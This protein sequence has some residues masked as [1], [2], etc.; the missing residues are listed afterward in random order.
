MVGEQPWE[1]YV[2]FLCPLPSKGGC[3]KGSTSYANAGQAGTKHSRSGSVAA[4]DT[5][6]IWTLQAR[7]SALGVWPG[8]SGCIGRRSTRLHKSDSDIALWELIS[9]SNLVLGNTRH[10][11][12]RAWQ[13]VAHCEGIK[14]N[15]S[16]NFGPYQ[17]V[18]K[19]AFQHKNWSRL[20]QQGFGSIS[21]I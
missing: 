8:I 4:W 19:M 6:L 18:A 10:D 14:C 15:S 12:R 7:T 16:C 20:P 17:G 3:T 13:A 11:T 2:Q 5:K 21:G 9:N 1:W